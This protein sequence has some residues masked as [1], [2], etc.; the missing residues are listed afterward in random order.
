MYSGVCG[1]LMVA[2]GEGGDGLSE[3]SG[4]DMV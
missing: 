3:D 1:S 4:S 2:A